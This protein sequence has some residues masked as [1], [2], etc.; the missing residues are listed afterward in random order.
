MNAHSSGRVTPVAHRSLVRM[1]MSH[2]GDGIG[3][4]TNGPHR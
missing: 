1:S 3:N 4:D 2:H